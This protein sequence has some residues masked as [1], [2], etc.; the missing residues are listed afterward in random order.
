MK[1]LINFFKDEEG[2]TMVEYGHY[3]CADCGCLSL[4]SSRPLG[5]ASQ[6]SV[7]DRNAINCYCYHSNYCKR[8]NSESL[9]QKVCK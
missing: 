9:F 3:G 8:D 4:A 7:Y 1:K 5:D 2:A 6:C